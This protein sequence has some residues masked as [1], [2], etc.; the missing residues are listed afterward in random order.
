MILMGFDTIEINLVCFHTQTHHCVI[1]ITETVLQKTAQQN[2]CENLIL[3]FLA[4]LVVLLVV[5]SLVFE[6]ERQGCQEEEYC[7]DSQE[8]W[9][10][11]V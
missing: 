10:H 2:K 3:L 9:P 5:V 6:P 11:Q 1:L 7:R 8:A 4:L